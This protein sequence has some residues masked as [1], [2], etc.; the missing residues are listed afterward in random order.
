LRALL[1]DAIWLG[2]EVDALLVLDVIRWRRFQDLDKSAH[3]KL[4]CRD[5]G[6]TV[7]LLRR[8]V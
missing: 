5:A 2:R 6:L 8:A 1:A 4:I 3:Y 7:A